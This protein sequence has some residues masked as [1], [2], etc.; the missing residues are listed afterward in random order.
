METNY[1]VSFE[2]F[3]EYC[4]QKINTLAHVDGT[5]QNCPIKSKCYSDNK[6][7]QID[8]LLHMK[9]EDS[10]FPVLLKLL[11]K[12]PDILSMVPENVFRYAYGFYHKGFSCPF[13]STDILNNLNNIE[14]AYQLLTDEQSKLTF[15]NVLMFRLTQKRDYA[16]KA[17]S[18]TPQ[19]FIPAFR[20]LNSE[21]VYVDCGAYIG[22]SFDVYCFY[23]NPP[24]VAY[25]FEPDNKNRAS[26]KSVLR[27]YAGR[28]TINVIEKGVYNF[29]GELYF[30]AGKGQACYLSLDPVDDSFPI[31]VTSIDDAINED[32][33]FIKMDI[34][35]AEKEALIGAKEHI[36]KSYPKLAICIYH[37]V[38]DFWEI[39][40]MISELFPGYNRFEVC[41]HTKNACD[42][43]L[44]VYK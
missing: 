3:R 32:I 14:Q 35:G 24:K 41:H 29:S 4:E 17:Y 15:L 25:M 10:R 39:P 23:N 33:S 2:E 8:S 40:I 44:Y 13:C 27:K 11:Q 6:E 21:E 20:G 26:M 1:I 18:M 43:V 42:T 9:R 37:H 36:S 12:R 19:Y 30:V 34:E 5:C 31:S 7:A 38:S 28:T 16:M 22:D